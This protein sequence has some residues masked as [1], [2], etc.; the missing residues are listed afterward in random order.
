M[1][2]LKNTNLDPSSADGQ[3]TV[4]VAGMSRTG[5]K[6]Q[7]VEGLGFGG[8]IGVVLGLYRGYV[9]VIV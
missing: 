9:R 2:P 4:K 8:Y 1:G 3:V 7:R 5:S 6:N